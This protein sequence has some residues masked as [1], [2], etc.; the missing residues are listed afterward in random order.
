MNWGALVTY[1]FDR[2]AQEER[3]LGVEVTGYLKY[4]NLKGFYGSQIGFCNGL[5]LP[6]WRELCLVFPGLEEMR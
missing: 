6:L 2:I 1:E 3:N 5:V 4:S